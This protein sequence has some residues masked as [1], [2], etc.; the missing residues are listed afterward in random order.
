MKL[1]ANR[2]A[3]AVA[4][5]T[6]VLWVLCVAFVALAPGP[7]MEMTGQMVHAD[8]SELSWSLTWGGVVM[9]FVWWIGFSAL[10]AWLIAR[11]YNLLVPHGAP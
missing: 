9:G 1:D 7:T 10:T 4:M 11:T 3:L 5:V 6:T 8:L 2:L